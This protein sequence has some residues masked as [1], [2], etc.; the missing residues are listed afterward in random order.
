MPQL[1]VCGDRRP[2]GDTPGGPAPEGINTTIVKITK[3]GVAVV[4]VE[5]NAV[6]ALETADWAYLLVMGE[7]R[8]EGPGKQLLTDPKVREVYLG[9]GR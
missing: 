7:N 5:Q 8:M 4:M 9:G 2:K 6:L 1:T 3:E